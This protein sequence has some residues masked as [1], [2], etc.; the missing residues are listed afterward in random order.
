M[1]QK[2]H[3]LEVEIDAVNRET[4]LRQ[5]NRQ[6]QPDVAESD[7]ADPRAATVQL[8][9]ETVGTTLMNASCL[10]VRFHLAP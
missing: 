9:P 1:I 6:A 4:R 10:L 7:D 8:L 2:V 5:L 3:P